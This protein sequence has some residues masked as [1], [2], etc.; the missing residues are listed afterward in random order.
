MRSAGA[1]GVAAVLMAMLGLAR[2][3]FGTWLRFVFPLFL[4][5]M[6]WSAVFLAIA[7][8]IGY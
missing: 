5:L 3:P 2:I 8:V 6:A 4:I 1:I 7:T